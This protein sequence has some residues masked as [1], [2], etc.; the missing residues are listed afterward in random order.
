FEPLTSFSSEAEQLHLSHP[1]VK[2]ILDR[3]S[4]Q[5]FSAHD[6]SRRCAVV[7]PGESVARVIVYGRLTIFGRS[8]ARLHDELVAV[9]A[10]WTPG[11]TPS[12]YKDPV[13]AQRAREV[14]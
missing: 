13:T 9:A 14:T 5:G 1:L 10:A 8:A 6:L 7:V 11:E 3:F 12:P 4:A 2:R